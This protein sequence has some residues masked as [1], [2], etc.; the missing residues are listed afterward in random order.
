MNKADNGRV[1]FLACRRWVRSR[2]WTDAAD[3]HRNGP[4][5]SYAECQRTLLCMWYY[6]EVERRR[7]GI[8]VLYRWIPPS[9]RT[10]LSPR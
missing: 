8:R 2:G 4:G 6:G 1:R 10:P 3:I 9:R 5:G 7:D